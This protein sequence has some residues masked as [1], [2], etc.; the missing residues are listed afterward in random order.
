MTRAKKQLFLGLYLFSYIVRLAYR[1]IEPGYSRDSCQILLIINEWIKTNSFEGIKNSFDYFTIPIFPLYLMKTTSELFYTFDAIIAANIVIGSTIPIICYII[2]SELTGNAK[3]SFFSAI[4][5]FFNKD[6]I[7]YSIET[8]RDC[9]FFVL[10]GASLIFLL[11]FLKKGKL[12]DVALCSLFTALS[13]LTRY[14]GYILII[15]FGIAALLYFKKKL[16]TKTLLCLGLYAGCILLTTKCIEN[17][18]PEGKIIEEQSKLFFTNKV[19]TS[20]SKE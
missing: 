5:I 14:E 19:K 12:G 2:S 8:Q 15:F 11:K 4:I 7:K 3:V 1:I 16:F 9:L 6:I 18:F 10:F 17:I 13:L 20:V